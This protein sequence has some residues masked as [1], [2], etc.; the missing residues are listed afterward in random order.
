MPTVA[1]VRSISDILSGSKIIQM[2]R[3][4]PV[5]EE[6]CSKVATRILSDKV[7]R[8]SVPA[9]TFYHREDQVLPWEFNQTVADA[10]NT[11]YL[12][13]GNDYVYINE[14][15][16]LLNERTKELCL[17]DGFTAGNNATVDVV[18]GVGATVGTACAINDKWIRVGTAHAEGSAAPD[19]LM[20]QEVQVTSYIPFQRKAI[21]LTTQAMKTAV[22]HGS[23]ILHQAAKKMIEFKL[24]LEAMMF[25]SA[26]SADASGGA[27]TGR[28]QLAS[29]G[30]Y[31]HL[32]TNTG[33]CGT[34]TFAELRDF[35]DAMRKYHPTGKFACIAGSDVMNIISDF[36]YDSIRT[37]VDTKTFGVNIQTL[38]LGPSEVSLIEEPLWTGPLT[39]TTLFGLPEPIPDF[40][41]LATFADEGLKW[42]IDCETEND[43]YIRKDSLTS[44]IGLE[45]WEEKKMGYL[46]DIVSG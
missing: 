6:A 7:G 29:A 44:Q 41:K 1:L 13:I 26:A 28:P 23:D 14:G 20:T 33:A 16:L 40:L 21:E 3:A 42:K 15:D 35:F 9:T 19:A 37:T 30:L 8:K 34:L 38:K 2:D 24:D 25:W 5:L 4:L 12:T 10:Y 18:R 31:D 11:A 36:A 32:S 39:G 46:E 45:I 27:S 43:V 22:Y 17:V